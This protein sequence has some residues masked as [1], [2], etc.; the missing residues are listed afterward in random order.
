MVKK[1]LKV[2]RRRMAILGRLD[3][4]VGLTFASSYA[5]ALFVVMG[6]FVI[7]DM[8]SNLDDYLEP[9]PDG[10][11]VSSVIVAGY[12]LFNLPFL[13][14]QA[15]PF[16]TLIAGLFTLTRLLGNNE[17]EACLAAGVSGRRLMMPIFFGGFVAMIG[18]AV[19]RESAVTTVLPTRDALHYLLKNK[20]TDRVYNNLHM[21]DLSG[22]LLRFREYRPSEAGQPA[23]ALDLL[24]CLRE[25]DR[26]TYVVRAERAVEGERDGMPGLLLEGG[27]R[28]ENSDRQHTTPLDWLSAEE[29]R[30]TPEMALSYYRARENPLELSFLEALELGRRDPDNVVYQTL[31]QYHLTFPLANLV[32]LLVGLPLVMRHERARGIEGVAKGLLLCLFF[33][34]ADFVCRSLGVQGSLDPLLASWLPVL[35]FGSLGVVLFDAL[36]T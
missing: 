6:L 36:R 35:F 2:H 21:R 7:M 1:R 27:T 8:A 33:F 15:A 10:S 28:M 19:L 16:I 14:L 29:F 13:F 34:A 32:L 24:A 30:F 11:T 17:V 12:Y 26:W 31:M 22:S 20:D 4:Y 5:T 25:G 23:Y 18:M 9:W 3:R